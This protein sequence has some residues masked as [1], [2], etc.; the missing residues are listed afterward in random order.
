[1]VDVVAG[2]RQSAT[3]RE[4]TD[5]RREAVED[6]AE[7]LRARSRQLDYAAALREG[8]ADRERRD[9]GRAGRWSRTGWESPER[10]GR[11][12]APR[13]SCAFAR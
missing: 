3:L 10:A 4:I 7:Y 9:R 12:R 6:C 5:A 11:S 13:P 1:M 8:P 2:V